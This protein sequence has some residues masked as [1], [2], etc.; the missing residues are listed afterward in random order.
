MCFFIQ[1]VAT[2]SRFIPEIPKGLGETT[3]RF[4]LPPHPVEFA[5]IGLIMKVLH[6]Q[7]LKFDSVSSYLRLWN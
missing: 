2:K 3:G 4:M 1:M 7:S 5:W 6:T